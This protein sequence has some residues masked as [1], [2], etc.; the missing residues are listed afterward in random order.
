MLRPSLP[1]VGKDGIKIKIWDPVG[2]CG[3]RN[4]L[5]WFEIEDIVFLEFVR[6]NGH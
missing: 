1:D 3:L 6:T 4:V 5:R 2:G